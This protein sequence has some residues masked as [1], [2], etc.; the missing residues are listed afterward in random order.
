MPASVPHGTDQRPLPPNATLQTLDESAMSMYYELNEDLHQ[1]TMLGGES[2]ALGSFWG[3]SPLYQSTPAFEVAKVAAFSLMGSRLDEHGK[4][5]V[6]F[7]YRYHLKW[8]E[9]GKE[10]WMG[11]GLSFYLR[12]SII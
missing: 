1:T 12:T 9:G 4:G 2:S 11:V 3:K 7:E 6:L 10:A 8:G 5:K